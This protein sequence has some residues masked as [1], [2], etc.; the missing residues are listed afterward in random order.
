MGNAD[1]W[2]YWK[3]KNNPTQFPNKKYFQTSDSSVI[4]DC[5]RISDNIDSTPNTT[6]ATIFV[7]EA[8]GGSVKYPSNNERPLGPLFLAS[9]PTRDRVFVGGEVLLSLI[10]AGTSGLCQM[11]LA[12][13]LLISLSSRICQSLSN[14]PSVQTTLDYTQKKLQKIPRIMW[15]MCA[16]V[17]YAADT[18]P[19]LYYTEVSRI[20]WWYTRIWCLAVFLVKIPPAL[21]TRFPE[22]LVPPR[23][24]SFK[25]KKMSDYI[26]HLK[27]LRMRK[28]RGKSSDS[29]FAG[30]AVTRQLRQSWR[31]TGSPWFET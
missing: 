10:G 8:L 17:K 23:S 12:P 30:A 14:I 26:F 24:G 1:N 21:L 9:S 7:L 31:G 13:S 6:V 11:L 22:S 18:C 15:I 25:G 16:H 2:Y 20:R 19:V 29:P 28:C 27:D 3:N 4:G 5:L